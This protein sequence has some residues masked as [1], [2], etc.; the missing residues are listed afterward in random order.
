MAYTPPTAEAAY[1]WIRTKAARND[2][3][4]LE[5]P[6]HA[7]S[8]LP[9]NP[10]AGGGSQQSQPVD[11]D[12]QEN[13]CEDCQDE[14]AAFAWSQD[15][16]DSQGEKTNA[17]LCFSCAAAHHGVQNERHAMPR[18]APFGQWPR[19]QIGGGRKRRRPSVQ[20]QRAARLPSPDKTQQQP[21]DHSTGWA[22]LG[23]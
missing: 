17:P 15:Q 7:P 16:S 11:D 19:M 18:L 23:S 9:A 14:A 2:F 5:E 20:R 21:V 13:P 6:M 8:V 1:E 12:E 4:Q 10:P 3:A 22:Q